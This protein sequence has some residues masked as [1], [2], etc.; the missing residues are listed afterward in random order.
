MRIAQVFLRVFDKVSAIAIVIMVRY[1]GLV[2]H[3]LLTVSNSDAYSS[4]SLAGYR[5]HTSS[6]FRV[7]SCLL[8]EQY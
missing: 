4:R 8:L 2:V 7:H 5:V 1:C 3:P 6:K